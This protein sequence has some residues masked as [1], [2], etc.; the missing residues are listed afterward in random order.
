[1]LASPAVRGLI[2]RGGTLILLLL[3]IGVSCP[4]GLAQ[5]TEIAIGDTVRV[6]T[7]GQRLN[8]R[9]QPGLDTEV[10]RALEPGTTAQ[11]I[12]GPE[13]IDG[14]VWWQI[15]AE[16]DQGWA[17]ARFLQ[18]VALPVQ[19]TPTAQPAT[20]QPTSAI[21]TGSRHIASAYGFSGWCPRGWKRPGEK[22]KVSFKID[23][24][25]TWKQAKEVRDLLANLGYASTA[26]ENANA[27]EAGA[28]LPNDEIFF[29]FGHGANN[30]LTFHDDDC[31][32]T[33]LVTGEGPPT[34]KPDLR[35]VV[36]VGCNTG[37]DT[38]DPSNV[39]RQF[40]QAGADK[41]I[42]FNRSIH[43]PVLKHWNKLFWE[44]AVLD[45]MEVGDAANKAAQDKIYKWYWVP[46]DWL[47]VLGDRDVYLEITETTIPITPSTPELPVPDVEGLLDRWMET[48][49]KR[50]ERWVSD[51]ERKLNEWFERLIE[52]FLTRLIALIEEFVNELCAT[53][54]LGLVLAGGWQLARS[55]KRMRRPRGK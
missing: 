2:R 31:K 28:R 23:V 41:V 24:V 33:S 3:I 49:R 14:Y 55:R 51:L 35:L 15:E 37:Y 5:Q 8:L 38:S 16:S 6:I 21:V 46:P 20:P 19:E 36:L 45:H 30:G 4:T 9:A 10:I 40:Y 27:S 32:Q 48:I 39:M 25:V 53:P 50:W 22:P 7:D 11:V 17:A 29:F 13:D 47:E 44:Y 43:A 52:Q 26:Y 12:D 54:V 18:T 34:P 42:G 1:M